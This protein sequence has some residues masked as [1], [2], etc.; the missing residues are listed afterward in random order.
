MSLKTRLKHHKRIVLVLGVGAVFAIVAVSA[1]LFASMRPTQTQASEVVMNNYKSFCSDAVK[2]CFKYPKDWMVTQD[3]TDQAKI[4]I[5]DNTGAVVSS[6]L[7][8]QRGLGAAGDRCP[9]NITMKTR[10]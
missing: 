5:K 8:K 3:D 4:E 1:I 10:L 6:L 2:M 7:R 9:N